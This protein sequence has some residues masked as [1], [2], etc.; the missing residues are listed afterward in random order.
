MAIIY[1]TNLV[2]G[3]F[4]TATNWSTDTV[5]GA[6]DQARIDDGSGATVSADETVLSLATNTGG[7]LAINGGESFHNARGHRDWCERRNYLL[8]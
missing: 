1:W 3:D 4:G 2:G 7:S 8:I 5:P 6:S